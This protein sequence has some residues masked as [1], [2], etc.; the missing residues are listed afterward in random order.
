MSSMSGASGAS[1][2]CRSPAHMAFVSAEQAAAIGVEL[3]PLDEL[4]RSAAVVSLH[5]P[6]LKETEG[7]ITGAHLAA[8][9][10]YATFVNTSRGALVHESELI[11]ALRERPDLCAV[12]DVTYPEPPPPE[13]PLYDMPNVVLTPHIAGSLEAECRRMG[14]LMVSELERFVRGEPLRYALTRAQVERMA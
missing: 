12:L 1:R 13:S 3:V 5:A 7:M 9:P 14:Q 10:P 4:F 8:M 2:A 6:W 11:A